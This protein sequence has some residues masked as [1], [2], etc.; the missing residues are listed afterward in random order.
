MGLAA[1][2]SNEVPKTNAKR[3][4]ENL[5]RQQMLDTICA[6]YNAPRLEIFN[7]ILNGFNQATDSGPLCEEPM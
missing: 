6:T 1:V 5:Q 7:G 2:N 3:E 4:E